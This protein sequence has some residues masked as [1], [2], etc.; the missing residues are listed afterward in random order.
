MN[1]DQLAFDQIATTL[2]KQFDSMY[3]VDLESDNYI[4]F[5]HS[6]MLQDLNLEEQGADFFKF[7]SEQA[8][9]IVHPDDLDYVLRLI[10]KEALLKKLSEDYSSLIVCRFV[11]NGEIVHV[12][13]LTVMCDDKKHILGCIK[14]IEYEFKEREE[15]ELKLTSA[16]RLSRLDELTGIKNKK[17]YKEHISEIDSRIN[18]D[19][20]DPQFGVI[21]CDIN[22]L[23]LINESRGYSF[24]D[25]VIQKSCRMICEIF[26]ESSVYRISGGQFVVILSGDELTNRKELLEELKKECEENGRLRSGPVIACGMAVYNSGVDRNFNEVFKRADGR[27]NVNKNELKSRNLMGVIRRHEESNMIMPDD[28]IRKLE[29]LYGV[30]H[31]MAGDGYI[32]LTD[33]KF[34]FSRWS[35]T[36]INDFDLPSEYMYSVEEI[37]KTRIHPEDLS[38]YEEAVDSIMHGTP[39]L[40]PI[41]YRARKV[42]GTYV[43]L[44]PRGFILN[45]S[46]G[47]PEYF[48][49]IM[50]PQ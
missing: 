25:E 9:R 46:N 40:Y 17:A 30:L 35:L 5:F 50:I 29:R 39:V 33:L 32:F 18:G 4:E 8:I 47:V 36:A 7:L 19:D 16:E 3:Y 38:R 23:K 6:Q 26:E 14:N 34:N 41:N 21:M 2:A 24:G 45:D 48:G 15:Q 22:D 27:M 42:D 44:K 28:R 12:C 31:T 37:W 1:I 49:G 10:N 20:I 13:H 43:I 11:L